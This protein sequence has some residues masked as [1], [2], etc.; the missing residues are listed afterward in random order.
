MIHYFER[1]SCS[2]CLNGQVIDCG[3]NDDVLLKKYLYCNAGLIC[4]YKNDLF[5]RKGYGAL[6][7]SCG[8]YNSLDKV[9]EVLRSNDNYYGIEEKI[10]EGYEFII[11]PGINVIKDSYGGN[12]IIDYALYCSNYEEILCNLNGKQ[13]KK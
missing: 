3:N 2:I 11:G 8:F 6:V 12:K 7:F 5:I 13:F 9:I 1:C 4:D 10:N